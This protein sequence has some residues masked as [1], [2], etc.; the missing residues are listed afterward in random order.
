MTGNE[1]QE[2][3]EFLGKK[4]DGIDRRFTKV[5]VGLEENRHQ[6]QVVAEGLASLRGEMGREFIAIRAEMREGF[7]GQGRAIRDLSARMDRWEPLSL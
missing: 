7:D 3:T 1:Y 6:T 4:F 2:L 5:E